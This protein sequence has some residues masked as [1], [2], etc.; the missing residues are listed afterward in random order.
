MYYC[1]DGMCDVFMPTLTS[2]VACVSH[3]NVH[4][5]PARVFARVSVII[6]SQRSAAAGTR[7]RS[8]ARLSGD[9]HTHVPFLLFGRRR[10]GLAR[11]MCHEYQSSRASSGELADRFSVDNVFP[12]THF[13]H[14][15][16]I[17]RHRPFVKV[18]RMPTT[19]CRV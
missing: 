10:V 17:R 9:T 14:L 11:Y 1:I 3:T 13:G 7:Q 19:K 15:P 18:L 8:A 6:L 2:C 16:R 12:L 5:R 4:A